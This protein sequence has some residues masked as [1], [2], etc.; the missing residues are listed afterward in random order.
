MATTTD[1]AK[2]A[3]EQFTTAGNKAFKDSFE[4]SMT[5]FTELNTDSKK[6]FEAVVASVT[7]AT[8]GA[9]TLGAQ[10]VAFSKKAVEDQVA[11]AKTL[12]AAK[13]VQEVIE[14]QTGFA[15]SAFETYVAEMNKMAE[16]VAASVKES[17]SPINARVTAFVERVQA[18]H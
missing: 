13:S 7:A 18:T 11:A 3:V 8:K 4:K 14:L 17:S 12:A 2:S 16:I 5:A 15:K 9:E 6:N 10:A 1:K